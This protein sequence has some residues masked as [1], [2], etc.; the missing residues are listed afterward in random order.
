MRLKQG[1]SGGAGSVVSC[2]QQ[3]DSLCIVNSTLRRDS[4]ARIDSIS[5][6]ARLCLHALVGVHAA[7]T[8][9]M[10]LCG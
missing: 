9:Q 10:N 2:N 7:A 5:E 1:L 6:R 4:A 8:P 3:S